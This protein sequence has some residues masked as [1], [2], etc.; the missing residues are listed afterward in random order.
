[1]ALRVRQAVL[2]V[3]MLALGA[4][5]V[6]YSLNRGRYDDLRFWF[7]AALTACGAVI[8]V[9]I[10]ARWSSGADGSDRGG[11]EVIIHE[12]TKD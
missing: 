12:K 1:M 6:W 5:A 2:V 8:C 3:V 7:V 11:F 4:V 10:S 9:V